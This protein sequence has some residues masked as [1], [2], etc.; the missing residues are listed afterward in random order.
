ML[1]ALRAWRKKDVPLSPEA[2]EKAELAKLINE[3]GIARFHGRVMSGVIGNG[4]LAYQVIDEYVARAARP[5]PVVRALKL[6][7]S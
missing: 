1:S 4:G 7:S 3:I 6:I 2:R 5:G